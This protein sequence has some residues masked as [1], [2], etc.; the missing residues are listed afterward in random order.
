MALP[1]P[2]EP[3]GSFA[4]QIRDAAGGLVTI[5]YKAR[6][7]AAAAC[8]RLRTAIPHRHNSL[9]REP[10]DFCELS[11]PGCG[12]LLLEVGASIPVRTRAAP[13]LKVALIRA[14]GG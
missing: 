13:E 7:A 4:P 11:L 10:M 3:A 5:S 6:S 8:D 14:D 12:G 2:A 9:E 1:V